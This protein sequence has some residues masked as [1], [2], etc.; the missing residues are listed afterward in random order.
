MAKPLQE[1]RKPP[2]EITPPARASTYSSHD[3]LPTKP[4][5]HESHKSHQGNP[6]SIT[7]Q[8]FLPK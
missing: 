2:L 4:I 3:R 8:I 1:G 5:P 7:N 6:K